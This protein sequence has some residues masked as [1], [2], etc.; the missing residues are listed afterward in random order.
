[1][2]INFDFG[3]ILWDLKSKNKQ[4]KTKCDKIALK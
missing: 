4:E 2:P 3:N 1:M